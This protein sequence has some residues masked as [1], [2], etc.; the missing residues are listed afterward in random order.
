MVK[1]VTIQTPLGASL[2]SSLNAN[3]PY[4]TYSQA[5]GEDGMR[6]CHPV[7]LRKYHNQGPPLYPYRAGAEAVQ[8]T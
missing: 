8:K 7:P 4:D 1:G 2:F 5:R 3:G 6:Y